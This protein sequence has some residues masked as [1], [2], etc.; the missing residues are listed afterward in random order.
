MSDQLFDTGDSPAEQT[1]TP[2]PAA[3][4]PLAVRIATAAAPA[5]ASGIVPA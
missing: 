1:R 5:R 4:A 3:D 2:V